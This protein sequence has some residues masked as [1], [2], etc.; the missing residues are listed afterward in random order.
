M[1]GAV[2]KGVK[3]DRRRYCLYTANCAATIRFHGLLKKLLRL[4]I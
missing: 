3:I 2:L 4:A 1:E